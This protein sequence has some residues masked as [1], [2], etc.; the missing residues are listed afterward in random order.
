MLDVHRRCGPAHH[1]HRLGLDSKHPSLLL[2]RFPQSLL[3]RLSTTPAVR[4]AGRTHPD[5]QPRQQAHAAHALEC[6]QKRRTPQPR[7]LRALR[8]VDR[9]R[10]DRP[11]RLRSGRSQTRTNYLRCHEIT[12][13]VQSLTKMHLTTNGQSLRC[14]L[15]ACYSCWPWP[16]GFNELSMSLAVARSGP[17]ARSLAFT[18]PDGCGGGRGYPCP[19]WRRRCRDSSD[20]NRRQVL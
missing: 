11:S 5:G 20:P 14:I 6:R 18:W 13:Q 1:R 19:T 16:A 9:Q 3:G 17:L 15:M 2:G 8:A 7:L 4:K 10:E 12:H